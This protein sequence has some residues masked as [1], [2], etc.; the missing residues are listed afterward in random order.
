MPT[1]RYLVKGRVQG[2]GFRYFALQEAQAL[3]LAGFARNLADGGVEV[4]AEGPDE[5]L[6]AFEARLKQ[7]PAFAKVTAVERARA[8]E[9]GDEG[10]HIR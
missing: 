3:G 2:V 6:A 5:A 10:F 4:L 7:G 1:Y 8:P 9:R